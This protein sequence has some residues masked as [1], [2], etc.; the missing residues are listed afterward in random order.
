[1]TGITA[2]P[3]TLT[4]TDRCDRCGAAASIRAVLPTGGELLFCGHHGREHMVRLEELA[5]VIHDSR[6]TATSV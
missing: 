4:A 6:A 1:M 3:I 5:A 2:A